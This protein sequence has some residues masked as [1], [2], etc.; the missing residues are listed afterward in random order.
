MDKRI[1]S[2]PAR[3]LYEI[4]VQ[5]VKQEQTFPYKK[6]PHPLPCF[7]IV[8]TGETILLRCLLNCVIAL[9][10]NCTCAFEEQANAKKALHKTA[11]LFHVR[12]FKKCKPGLQQSPNVYV[13]RSLIVLSPFLGFTLACKHFFDFLVE[14]GCDLLRLVE[15][16]IFGFS[17]LLRS[18]PRN[19]PFVLKNVIASER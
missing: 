5:N 9:R 19:P 11:K 12:F 8:E 2:T 6:T 4:C 18:L 17:F 16:I 10:Q 15:Y 14:V 13:S 7:L 1:L 3:S